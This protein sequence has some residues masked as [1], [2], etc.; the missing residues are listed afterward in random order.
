MSAQECKCRAKLG[1]NIYQRMQ[2]DPKT[3]IDE[4][5]K[6]DRTLYY[7]DTYHSKDSVT[8][9]ED[10]HEI[11][12]PLGEFQLTKKR[13]EKLHRCYN[14]RTKLNEFIR[15]DLFQEKKQAELARKQQIQQH[16]FS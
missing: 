5:V 7:E 10:L 6:T 13:N 2:F 9:N 11:D 3:P 12:E 8:E 14:K 4:L 1:Q 16:T 15:D